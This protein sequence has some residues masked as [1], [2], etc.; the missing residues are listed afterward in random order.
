MTSTTWYKKYQKPLAVA[1]A[2]AVW[3][4][5][6]LLISQELLLP[7]P[8]AVVA[9]LFELVPTL[10]FWAGVAFSVARIMAGY[11]AGIF[12]GVVFAF[13]GARFGAV[14]ALLWPWMSLIKATPVASFTILCLIW[15]S[16]AELSVFIAFLMVL[17][18]VYTNLLTGLENIDPKLLE[19]AAVF[20]MS[21]GR[22]L[23]YITLPHLRPYIMSACGVSLGLAWKAGIAAE[24]I[25][26]PIGSIGEQLYQAKVHFSS[27]DLFAWTLAVVLLSVGLEKLLMWLLKSAFGAWEG[28]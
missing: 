22:V 2:V 26:I 8:V 19:M 18:I 13:L 14:K 10:A 7:S 20:G 4:I 21:R 23:G 6:A 1:A 5:A 24:V 17:P 12:A 25:G 9:R 16:S 15:L 27:P 3:Q 28:Q 11:L